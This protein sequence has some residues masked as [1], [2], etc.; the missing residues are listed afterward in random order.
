MV[1]LGKPL[2]YT[3]HKLYIQFP[4]FLHENSWRPITL[5]ELAARSISFQDQVLKF[6]RTS[7]LA[8]NSTYISVTFSLSCAASAGMLV[9]PS[10]SRHWSMAKEQ[11]QALGHPLRAG[12]TRTRSITTTGATIRSA[13]VRFE[14]VLLSLWK[15]HPAAGTLDVRRSDSSLWPAL[16]VMIPS[17]SWAI[18]PCS[19]AQGNGGLLPPLLLSLPPSPRWRNGGEGQSSPLV[20]CECEMRESNGHQT[21]LWHSQK[22]VGKPDCELQVDRS[23]PPVRAD[24]ELWAC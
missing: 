2:G 9:I 17:R 1:W 5:I 19:R 4:R 15:L 22:R 16:R 13:M 12:A 8:P 21:P 24:G 10:G 6:P 14:W 3:M 20:E 7:K 18:E 23:A 11:R